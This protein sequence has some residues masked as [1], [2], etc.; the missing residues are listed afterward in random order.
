[1]VFIKGTVQYCNSTSI[2]SA[3][4]LSASRPQSDECMLTARTTSSV[5]CG[6]HFLS[7]TTRMPSIWETERI[8][9]AAKH[10]YSSALT[11]SS[12]FNFSSHSPCQNCVSQ[13]IPFHCSVSIKCKMWNL[14]WILKNKLSLAV[15]KTWFAVRWCAPEFGKSAFTPTERN[16]QL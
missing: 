8:T 5:H 9:A 12:C 3:D 6:W 1:M 4:H 11:V 15:C 14:V 7:L 16:D 2:T 13:N 10:K